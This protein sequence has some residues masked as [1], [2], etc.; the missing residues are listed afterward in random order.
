MTKSPDLKEYWNDRGDQIKKFGNEYFYTTTEIP[1]YIY[2]RE[3]ILKILDGFDFK[4]KKILDYGCGDGFYSQY[5]NKRGASVVGV[6][7]SQKMIDFAKYK[8]QGD[9][10]GIS[11]FLTDGQ[12][13]NFDPDYFDF[14]I[15][16]LVLQHVVDEKILSTLFSEFSRTL[17]ENGELIHFDGVKKQSQDGGTIILRNKE[18]YVKFSENN[19]FHLIDN[20]VLSSPFYNLAIKS[21]FLLKL[22]S[23]KSGMKP[24]NHNIVEMSIS[25][26]AVSITRILDKWWKNDN[27][28]CGYFRY[29]KK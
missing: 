10:D 4:E 23:Q 3:R 21:Y 28:G 8:Y 18:D 29:S 19:G 22:I 7:I 1:Y 20:I 13:L 6:D 26:I 12:S 11:F 14:I 15:S 24:R 17:K 27:Y 25:K 5:F 16:S 2:R 9:N